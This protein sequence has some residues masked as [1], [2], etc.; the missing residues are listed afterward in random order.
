MKK[1]IL[2]SISSLL[3]IPLF[4][5]ASINTNLYYGLGENSD[6]KQLQEFLID[7][8]FLTGNATGNFYSLTLKA[9]KAYQASAG[10]SP[11]GYVGSITRGAINSELEK[12]LS[13]SDTEAIKETGAVSTATEDTRTALLAVLKVLQDRMAE[14]QKNQNQQNTTSQQLQETIQQQL[15]TLQIIQ[16]NTQQIV[17]N[18]C[19]PNWQCG[20]WTDCL[21]SNQTRTCNDLNS[22]NTNNGKPILSQSCVAQISAPTCNLTGEQIGISNIGKVSW[23]STNATSGEIKVYY[24]DSNPPIIR[25]LW[26]PS[27]DYSISGVSLGNTISTGSYQGFNI[28]F[29][30]TLYGVFTGPGGTSSCETKIEQPKVDSQIVIGIMPTTKILTLRVVSTENGHIANIKIT[31]KGGDDDTFSKID[32]LNN[33]KLVIATSTF[34]DGVAQFN[35]IKFAT[36]GNIQVELEVRVELKNK[37]DELITLGIASES[38]VKSYPTAVFQNGVK[39][40]WGKEFSAQ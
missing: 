15:Q 14:S 33:D 36:P 35:D 6:V 12:D 4:A 7:K 27:K 21:N 1:I 26:D 13:G 24:N 25:H 5:S 31:K 9:V 40:L 29:G 39:E 18:T 22:C 37:T 17:N 2:F 30:A 32:L 34:K 3:F 10:I 11:T 28:T 23:T 38:D 8:G 16:Q 20:F 19:T